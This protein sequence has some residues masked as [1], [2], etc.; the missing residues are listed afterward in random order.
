M[1]VKRLNLF[2]QT[3]TAFNVNNMILFKDKS[4]L[5]YLDNYFRLRLYENYSYDSIFSFLELLV[6]PGTLL[7]YT[8]EFE[9]LYFFMHIPSQ[10]INEYET[11]YFIIGPFFESLPSIDT[12][13]VIMAQRQIPNEL[14]KDITE[15]YASV[16]VIENIHMFENLIVNLCSGLFQQEYEVTYL[17]DG[18]SISIDDVFP[19]STL[20][21]KPQIAISSIEER[22][23]VEANMVNAITNG[24]FKRA[25]E[26]HQ[27]L[28]SYYIHPRTDNL[29]RNAQ[30]F[31]IILNTLCRKA[32][33]KSGVH[34]LYI[35]ELS[36]KFSILI[37]QTHSQKE[38]SHLS[39]DMIHKYCLLVKNH[40]MKGYSQSVKDIISY[41]DFHYA[42]DLSLSFFANMFSLTKTYLSGLF[43]KETGIT[44]TDFIHQVRIRKALTLLNSSSLPI[45][46]IA[47]ACGYNDINYF[48][49]TF[50]KS[51][52][53]SPKQYQK[54]I[55]HS[56]K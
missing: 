54:S 55:L 45:A 33:E 36:T 23:Q 51:C 27:K 44:L 5:S 11:S 16:P 1:E 37:N 8:D 53:M 7:R 40:A 10:Y 29:L 9:M 43:K 4:N 6:Q 21:Q 46:T 48:I 50:K 31:Q 17:P 20:R 52:G 34:P 14:L 24:D 2:Q 15:F 25:T 41:I 22:Y 42:E 12:I 35:D 28:S 39:N 30:N 13:Q 3:L 47:T 18:E 56:R 32:V 19:M 38:T 26:M 49:R